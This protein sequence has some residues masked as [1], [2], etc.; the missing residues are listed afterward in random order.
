LV[1]QPPVAAP[2]PEACLAT[3]WV[4]A[5]VQPSDRYVQA[6]ARSTRSR[7]EAGDSKFSGLV[8]AGDWTYTG[9][10]V[11]CVEA[12]VMSGRLASNALCGLPLKSAI[13]GYFPP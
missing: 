1:P 6:P 9:L 8:L 10:N 13:S 4:R 11:G 7:L 12:A 5:N 3:Q 2:S